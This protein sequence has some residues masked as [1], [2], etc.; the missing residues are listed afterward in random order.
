[1]GM[2]RIFLCLCLILLVGCQSGEKKKVLYDGLD[3]KQTYQKVIDDFN[4]NVTYYENKLIDSNHNTIIRDYY[5]NKQQTSVVTKMVF[6]DEDEAS[7][8]YNIYETNNYHTLYANGETYEYQCMN[9]YS[10]SRKDLYSDY[11][12]D[13]KQIIDASR[14]D[15]DDEIHLSI[16]TKELVTYQVDDDGEERYAMHEMVINPNGYI[17]SEK[18]SYYADEQFDS[19]LEETHIE[20]TD[21]NQKDMKDLESEIKLMKSCDGLE[22]KEVAQKLKL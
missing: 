1:M 17:S 19:V 22:Y 10:G 11:N 13:Q 6:D 14:K 20:N 5:K 16:K 9:D 18:I 4:Q 12:S 7:L 15:N 3:A 2:K 21:F 8:I